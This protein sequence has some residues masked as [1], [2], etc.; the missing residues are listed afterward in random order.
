MAVLPPVNA[1][2]WDLGH[3]MVNGR[4]TFATAAVTVSQ[5]RMR[6]HSDHPAWQV[7]IVPRAL[8]L[9]CGLALQCR[10]D[11]PM[12]ADSRGRREGISMDMG[13]SARPGESRA[14]GFV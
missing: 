6:H 1:I 9:A 7:R 2:L 10:P 3:A 13:C 14:D 11:A 4:L 5:V 8:H 12:L